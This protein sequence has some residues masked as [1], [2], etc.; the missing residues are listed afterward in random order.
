MCYM[1]I[2]TNKY[3]FIFVK[4]K[5][6]KPANLFSRVAV[7]FYVL[8]SSVCVRTAYV[9]LQCLVL[10]FIFVFF[11]FSPFQQVCT[12]ICYSLS[13]PQRLLSPAPQTGRGASVKALHIC[14]QCTDPTVRFQAVPEFRPGDIRENENRKLTTGLALLRV[15]WR[16]YSSESSDGFFMHSIRI[17]SCIQWER[18]SEICLLAKIFHRKLI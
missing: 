3:E 6:Q 16:P 10:S 18:Q 14:T 13:V 11:K 1:N 2:Y 15:V 8:T 17:L 4:H 12:V 7:P 5:K 9:L